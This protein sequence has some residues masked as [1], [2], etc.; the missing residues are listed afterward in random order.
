MMTTQLISRP[1]IVQN[2][3]SLQNSRTSRSRRLAVASLAFVAVLGLA[4]CGG[5]DSDS[6]SSSA[7]AT[8]SSARS[9]GPGG[10]R[11]NPGVSGVISGTGSGTV[12]FTDSQ[13][14]SSTVKYT[15]DTTISKQ[16]S[17]T[18]S[19]LADGA[20]VSVRQQFSGGGAA[21]SG[22]GAP[23]G[24]PTGQPG[25]GQQ[26]M[27]TQDYSKPI[28]ATSVIAEPAASCES[29]GGTGG[30]GGFGGVTGKITST[31]SGTFTMQA[32]VVDFSGMQ[33]DDAS[34]GGTPT[35]TPS[36]TP[37]TVTVTVSSDTTYAQ[38]TSA[39]SDALTAG[40]CLTA[41]GQTT[42]STLTARSMV[43]STSDNGTCDSG[44]GGMGRG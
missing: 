15:G 14:S 43:I 3:R 22:G 29:T 6:D 36:A 13:G 31:G 41:Q 37:T 33:P 7:A 38:Q 16:T 8:P 26:A 32:Q 34:H 21:P 42:D 20:C 1:R 18:S 5:S 4:G 39:G 40:L 9:G 11:M 27:P 10:G 28:A 19:I 30:F 44:F 35:A 23:S 2:S 12:T 25:N 24:M 17:A